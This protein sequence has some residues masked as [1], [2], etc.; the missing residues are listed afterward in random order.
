MYGDDIEN[1]YDLSAGQ[2]WMLDQSDRADSAFFLQ[3]MMRAVIHLDPP[4]FRRKVDSVS[5]KRDSLRSAFVTEGLSRPVRVVLKNRRVELLF[6]DITGMP[7]DEQ[8]E[9]LS[10]AAE[11][12]RRQGFDMAKVLKKNPATASIPIIFLTAKDTED[13]ILKGFG[14]GADDYISKPFFLREVLA[15]VKA[16]LARTSKKLDKQEDVFSYKGIKVNY[17]HK[18]V[19]VND[20]EVSVTRTEFDIL[21]LLLSHPGKV[22]SRQELIES[23]WPKDTSVSAK[24]V[25]GSIRD[26]RGKL[27][28]LS[29]HI[30]NKGGLGY[31]FE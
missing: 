11:S 16:V 7:P 21:R 9:Y 17:A 4:S 19:W 22:F 24:V 6:K 23:V 8:E 14:L 13:D 30:V 18:S 28:D 20:S 12:D 2:K 5:E 15:R 25:D 1:V 3:V 27:G 31:C 29:S 26:I 10:K